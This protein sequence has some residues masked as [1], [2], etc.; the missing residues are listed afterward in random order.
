MRRRV[1]GGCECGAVRYV[2]DAVPKMIY[3][4]HC[5]RCQRQSSSAF[6]MAVLFVDGTIDLSG[7]PA[8]AYVRDGN[9]RKVRGYFCPECGTRLY[10]QW[11]NADG[12]LPFFNVKPGTLDDTSW[13]APG[14][15]MWTQHRQPWLQLPNDAVAFAEQPTPAQIPMF[16]DPAAGG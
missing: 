10:H 5:T 7:A 13:I 16:V 12:D 14:C 9:G 3:A 8:K 6:G 15:H 4:C 11:F 2:V 1:E